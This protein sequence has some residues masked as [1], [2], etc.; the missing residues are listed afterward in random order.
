MSAIINRWIQAHRLSRAV[1]VAIGLG[2]ILLWFLWNSPP[3]MVSRESQTGQVISA[4]KDGVMMIELSD[5]K[6]MR[7]FTP[8][9][10]PVAG[11]RVP[12]VVETYADGSVMAVIDVAA[13]HGVPR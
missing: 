2:A 3:A 13:W 5:G 6:Q 4:V 7:V 9:P 8:S 10:V 11:A 12:V 1:F